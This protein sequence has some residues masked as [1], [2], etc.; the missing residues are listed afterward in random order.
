MTNLIIGILGN[1]AVFG[2]IIRSNQIDDMKRVKKEFVKRLK[3]QG[4]G[5]KTLREKVYR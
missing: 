1:I 2:L 4:R 5:T 3:T